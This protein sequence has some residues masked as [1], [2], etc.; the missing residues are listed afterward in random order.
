MHQRPQPPC[1]PGRPTKAAATREGSPTGPPAQ[2]GS[3]ATIGRRPLLIGTFFKKNIRTSCSIAVLESI[4]K[5]RSLKNGYPKIDTHQRRLP[6]LSSTRTPA[7]CTHAR[8]YACPHT[9]THER[10]AP[11]YDARNAVQ[12]DARRRRTAALHGTLRAIT[13]VP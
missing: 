7:R 12:S 9:C 10:T 5:H 11:Q 3:V 4:P 6:R 8:T 2:C 1:S 13:N